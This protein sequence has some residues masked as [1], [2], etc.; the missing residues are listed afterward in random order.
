MT[1]KPRTRAGRRTPARARCSCPQCGKSMRV[2]V[3]AMSEWLPHLHALAARF[4]GTGIT[5]DL[6]ALCLCE[7]YGLFLFLFSKAA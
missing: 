5:P 2:E 3:M 7:A 4:S 6:A 1:T